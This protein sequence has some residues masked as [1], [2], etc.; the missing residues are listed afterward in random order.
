MSVEDEVKRDLDCFIDH[1]RM[2]VESFA[3]I[4]LGRSYVSDCN[5]CVQEL[6]ECRRRFLQMLAR[7]KRAH[8]WVPN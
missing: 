8:G 3:P 2:I 1:A 5:A 4:G 7:A 6:E